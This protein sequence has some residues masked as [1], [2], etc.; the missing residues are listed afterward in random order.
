V[1]SQRKSTSA[2]T[3]FGILLT[4]FL[5]VSAVVL[6][7]VLPGE[8]QAGQAALSWK[9]PTTYSDGTPL[10][11][12][13][14]Y[15][16]H[17]GNSSCSYRQTID[18]G[19]V[20]SYQTNNLADGAAYYFA[21]TAY[22]SSGTE[23]AYSNEKGKLLPPYLI[24]ASYGSGGTVTAL[25]NPNVTFQTIGSVTRAEL[26]VGDGASQAF[27]IAPASGNSIGDVKVDAKSVGKV[28]SYTFNMVKAGH[29]L[30][31]TFAGSNTSTYTITSSAGSGG[32]ITPSGAIVVPVGGSQ[33]FSI[34][35]SAGHSVSD[36]KVDGVSVGRVSSYSFTN[37]T[38]NHTIQASFSANTASYT[39]TASAGTGGS[40][41]PAG[42]VSVAAGGSQSFSITPAAGYSV[43]DVKVDGA[44]VG[45]VTTYSFPNLSANHTIQASFAAASAFAVNCGGTSYTNSAG[46]VYLT[47]T[48]YSGG[49]TY[50]TSTQVSGTNEGRLYQ[51]QRVGNFSYS[52]SLPNGKYN[53]TLKFAELTLSG[54]NRRVFSVAINGATV[55][56]NL[57]V[58]AKVGKYRAYDVVVPA[59]VSNGTLRISLAGKINS[60]ILS[61]FRVVASASASSPNAEAA[62]FSAAAVRVPGA[63]RNAGGNGKHA[64]E[65]EPAAEATTASISADRVVTW[66]GNVGVPGDIP[67]RSGICAT[68]SP[69]GGDD[70]G[71]LQGAIRDCPSGGVVLLAA[72]TF[73]VSAPIVVKSGITLRGAGMGRTVVKGAA[74]LPG[75]Y[76][77]GFD[78][79]PFQ[80]PSYP[81]G[82]AL[83]KDSSTVTTQSPHNWSV[84]DVILIDQLNNPTGTP[85]VTNQGYSSGACTWCGR[86]NG[87]RSLGQLDRITATP[88]P[89]TA[90]LESPLVWNYSSSLSP[91]LTRIKSMTTDAGI[92]DLTVDN[93]VSGS[94]N[95]INDGATIALYGAAN[96]WL[97]R[98]EAIGAHTTM[99]RMKR[100]YRN[101]IRGCSF[102][103]G[104]PALPVD[105]PSYGTSRAYGVWIGPGS[106]N[107]VEGNKLYH[108]FMPVKLDSP[109]SGNVIAYNYISE[110][111]YTNTNW[112]LGTV[113]MHGAHPAMNLVESNYS[114]G[115]M[116]ADDTWGSSSHNTFFRNRHTLTP[117]K[118]GA[119]WDVDLQK[120]ALYY[121]I[122]GNVIG[123]IGT[124][125]VYQFNN[126]DVTPQAAIFRFGYNSDGD[127]TAAD[128]DPQVAGSVFLNG[129]WDS[130]NK[131]V[132]WNGA[133]TTLPPSLYRSGK[134]PWWGARP[135]PA[136]GPDLSPMSPAAPGVCNGMPWDDAA[137]SSRPSP[138]TSLTVQ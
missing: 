132:V 1:S 128:N 95:Q 14:G 88:T 37:V 34:V 96:C 98:V 51:S 29:T 26:R 49:S 12:L 89:T 80:D 47:D 33:S 94:V 53:V 69:S 125:Q 122:V 48:N 103:E 10:G 123:S 17:I 104:V 127:G 99:I 8:A 52:K 97:L 137:G 101:T 115:R 74:G 136:V 129:N 39:I 75:S 61:A 44:S 56:S 41:S 43:S 107:L 38:A 60:A 85:V 113:N 77:V 81:A 15:R 76:L 63:E 70:T 111:Y 18:V 109:T 118:S 30:D 19:K 112:N 16:V 24:I 57:D 134:P 55:I 135:W 68:L 22:N 50:G 130:V 90:T 117:N 20:T 86:A 58:Y 31:V 87:G 92:E 42:A 9:A 65:P 11:D 40:I 2:I 23:S 83:S 28:T 35:P 64:G 54:S 4:C 133:A 6:A 13:A 25:N 67:A 102:H 138:P 36:L 114:D 79:V 105:H 32:T 5:L 73:E 3:P 21:V 66:A 116:L 84:G 62:P 59:T 126:V 100:A 27:S 45:R 72:G 91:E 46:V 106:G 119:P 78:A 82:G 121:N 124:E 93:S 7:P 110:L 108:L 131:S 120:N 71:A